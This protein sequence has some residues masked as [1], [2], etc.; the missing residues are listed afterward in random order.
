MLKLRYDLTTGKIGNA[1]SENIIVPE[2]FILI[3][4]EEN[5]AIVNRDKMYVVNGKLV[6]ITDTDK[7]QELNAQNQLK[8]LSEQ[9][10]K[11]KASVAYGGII[12][13]NQWVF[14][15]NS[16]SILMTTSKY[17][18]VM[19]NPELKKVQHWKCYTL[20]G[21]PQ[22]LTFTREQ[23]IQIKNFASN[24]ID[25]ECFGVENKYNQKLSKAT[26]KQLN[27]YSW[28]TKFKQGAIKEMSEINRYMDIGDITIG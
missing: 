5:G 25:T 11:L 26:V 13:N 3:T 21:I 23:F 18:D 22:F 1:Y 24:M 14:E 9:L 6:D 17:V 28:I 16:I 19:N 12:L 7:E 8:E 10:Y 15:T 20:D 27:S 4:E 2:P